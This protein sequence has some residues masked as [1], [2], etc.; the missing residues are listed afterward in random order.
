MKI[1]AY[2][3][4]TKKPLQNYQLQLQIKGKDSGYVTFKSDAKGE[5]TLEDKYKGQQMS[6]SANGQGQWTTITEGATLYIDTKQQKQGTGTTTS[7]TGSK[8]EKNKETW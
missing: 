4:T 8:S 2:D 6:S 7:T 1:K 5:F 3:S